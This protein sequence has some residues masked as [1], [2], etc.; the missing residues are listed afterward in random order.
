MY[1]LPQRVFYSHTGKRVSFSRE[2][3][4]KVII[5]LASYCNKLDCVSVSL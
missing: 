1:V 5:N 4:K 2:E 3:K